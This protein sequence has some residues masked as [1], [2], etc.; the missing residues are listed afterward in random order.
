MT[1]ERFTEE[2]WEAIR[3]IRHDW[4]RDI[5]WPEV[6]R[7]IEEAGCEY[8]AVQ[9]QREQRGRSA[10][11]KKALD[12]AR[13]SLISLQTMLSRL[14]T[15]SPSDLDGLPISGFKQFEKR[16]KE[17]DGQYQAWSTPFGGKKSW[18]RETLINRLVAI[19][20]KHLRGRLRSSKNKVQEPAGPLVR[21]LTLTLTAIQ[22]ES[23]GPHGIKSIID[24]V[25]KRRR[26]TSGRRKR[27]GKKWGQ[28]RQQN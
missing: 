6:R 23:P 7:Q 19:W 14:R 26:V 1:F 28:I 8:S 3:A 15:L 21:Y 25:K 11:Y 13:R 4:P 5:D 24:K 27:V 12:G 22:G 17:L 2:Q 10:A 18:I 20:K 9:H 16:L